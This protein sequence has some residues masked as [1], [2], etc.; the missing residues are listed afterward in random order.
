MHFGFLGLGIMGRAMAQ[1]LLNAGYQVTVYNR[2][3]EKCAALIEQGAQVE[4]T[5]KAVAERCDITIAMVSDPAA[6]RAICFGDEGV[7]AGIAENRGYVDMST[8]DAATAQ[9]IAQAITERG[10]R[11]LEAPVS[12]TKKPAE[13]GSLIILAAGDHQLYEEM[14]PAFEVMGKLSLFLGEV[15]QGAKMKLVVNMIMG[16]MLTIFSEGMALGEKSGLDGETI[17]QVLGAGAMA[18]PM[19]KGKGAMML[20][21]NYTTNFPLEHMQK[22][23]RLAVALGDELAQP[24]PMAATANETFKRARQAG[25]AEQDIVA[26]HKIIR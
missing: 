16:G 14:A 17:L 13:E 1:N 20:A 19:F 10:G 3:P 7:A 23:L 26:I 5:P 24:L 12:G 11:Y 21:E 2:T 25:L 9:S 15:G 22:D 18:N 8:V 6:A 4:S